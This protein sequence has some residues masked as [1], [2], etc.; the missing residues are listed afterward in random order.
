MPVSG[1]IRRRV[2]RLACTKEEFCGKH[3]NAEEKSMN[4]KTIPFSKEKL[5]EI[6]KKYPTPFHI[7]DERAIREN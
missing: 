6:I 5:E 3:Y 1:G 7:Y 4:N 2:G